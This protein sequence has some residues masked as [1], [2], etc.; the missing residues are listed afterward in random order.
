MSSSGQ[1]RFHE[2]DHE[3]KMQLVKTH[4]H[5][6]KRRGYELLRRHMSLHQDESLTKLRTFN[7][8]GG[9]TSFR[10]NPNDT[11]PIHHSRLLATNDKLHTI[12]KFHTINSHKR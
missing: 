12:Q 2:L 11:S 1:Y 9:T 8:Q 5:T 4:F 3:L 7:Y 6:F 10:M